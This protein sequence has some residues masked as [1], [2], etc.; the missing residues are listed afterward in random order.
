L[1][2]LN[3]RLNCDKLRRTKWLKWDRVAQLCDAERR[4]IQKFLRKHTFFAEF[5][6][7][8]GIAEGLGAKIT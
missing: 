5:G 6:G 1:D 7:G 3:L 2:Q 4:Q 8:T